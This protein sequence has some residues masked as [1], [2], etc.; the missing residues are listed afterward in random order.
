[1]LSLYSEKEKKPLRV[2]LLGGLALHHYGMKGRSTIDMDAEIEGDLESLFH[3][4]K[5]RNIP[6]DLSEN[7]S[8]WSIIAMPPGYRDRAI[9]ILQSDF[10]EVRVLDPTDFIIAK[11]RRFTEED[12]QDALFVA[13][14]YQIK[15]NQI[16]AASHAAISNSVKDTTL[17]LFKKNV[18]LFL[19]KVS[20]N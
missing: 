12:I 15:K 13:R 11:L 6:S 9:R 14:K 19:K 1:M 17:F 10:L 3:F 5:A 16:A 18:E 2:L 7:I 8:G 4:L 20:Q